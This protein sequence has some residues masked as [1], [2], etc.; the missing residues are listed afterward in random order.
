MWNYRVIRKGDEYGLYEVFYN[1]DGEISA[2]SEKPDIVG[3]SVEDLMSGL[4]LMQKDIQ[5]TIDDPERILEYGK[6][7]FH[8]F[9]DEEDRELYPFQV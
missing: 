4:S 1:D 3:E 2:H 7:K 5:R 6:I 9:C 8:P